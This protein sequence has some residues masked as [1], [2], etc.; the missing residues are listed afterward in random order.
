MK[1]IL[2]I[3]CLI[4]ISILI[5]S[6]HEIKEIDKDTLL[7]KTKTWKEP[8]VAIWYYTGSDD[9]F[10]YFLYQDLGIKE[11]Y[12]VNKNENII[13]E[14]NRFKP[15]SNSKKW[16]VMPWGIHAIKKN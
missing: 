9:D 8:K 6:C 14:G 7:V 5:S 16:K 15:Q 2:L 13:K 4:A 1:N 12:K 11:Y 3:F 10:D